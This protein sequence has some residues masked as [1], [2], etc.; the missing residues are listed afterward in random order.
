MSHNSGWEIILIIFL[1]IFLVWI[2]IIF[3]PKRFR[4][5]QTYRP[6]KKTFYYFY[7][8]HCPYCITFHS[9]WET[10]KDPKIDFQKIDITKPENKEKVS[11]FKI[12]KIPTLVLLR[13]REKIEYRGKRT[14]EEILRFLSQEDYSKYVVT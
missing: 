14:R 9:I 3:S 10:L 4:F 1:V 6:L 5:Y 2:I 12:Q 8:P 13:N 11:E 7:S